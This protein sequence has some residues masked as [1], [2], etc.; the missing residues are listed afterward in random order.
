VLKQIWLC[1]GLIFEYFLKTMFV[2][3]NSQEDGSSTTNEIKS[4]QIKAEG[5]ENK[6]I[7]LITRDKLVFNDDLKIEF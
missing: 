5:E 4:Y 3:S 6:S 1:E 2:V 7:S